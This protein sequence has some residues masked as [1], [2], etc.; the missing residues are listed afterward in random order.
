MSELGKR[1]L[2]LR[3]IGDLGVTSV[4]G[5]SGEE[6]ISGRGSCASGPTTRDPR[7]EEWAES[8]GVNACWTCGEEKAVFWPIST[9]ADPTTESLPLRLLEL[10]GVDRAAGREGSRDGCFAC[11]MISAASELESDSF[12]LWPQDSCGG[13]DGVVFRDDNAESS[14]DDWDGSGVTFVVRLLVFIQKSACFLGT[15]FFHGIPLGL[16]QSS[17]CNG[18]EESVSEVQL[19]NSNTKEHTIRSPACMPK[20]HRV[21]ARTRRQQAKRL[22]ENR[23]TSDNSSRR[24]RRFESSTGTMKQA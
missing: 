9:V 15:G 3:L 13:V 20:V 16:N 1:A 4:D 14:P 21:R 10:L 7:R 6:V 24:R 5:I 8:G 17:S 12:R 19:C 23:L 2:R 11:A 18:H 22:V